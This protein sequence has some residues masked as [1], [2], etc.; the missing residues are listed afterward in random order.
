M[1]TEIPRK[2]GFFNQSIS[3]R[4]KDKAYP[5]KLPT[6]SVVIV[7]H[8]EAWTTLLRTVWSVI[9]R[10]PRALLEEIILVDDKSERGKIIYF[11][12]KINFQLFVSNFRASW[13]SARRV[14]QDTSGSSSCF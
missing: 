7:F 2:G 14:L 12:F 5:D 4:C 6:T 13:V 3:H 9:N 11:P 8:N 10:S 1:L